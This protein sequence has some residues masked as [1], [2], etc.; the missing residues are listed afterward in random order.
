MDSWSLNS[1]FRTISKKDPHLKF[2]FRNN[3]TDSLDLCFLFFPLYL[4]ITPTP[5]LS[6]R[7]SSVDVNLFGSLMWDQTRLWKFKL[8]QT[9]QVV[10]R[11]L[12]TIP[13][14]FVQSVW[15]EDEST[16]VLLGPPLSWG[17]LQVCEDT[18]N[19]SR[20]VI[21]LGPGWCELRGGG[22][23]WSF[24]CFCSVST[25][26]TDQFLKKLHS[27]RSSEHVEMHQCTSYGREMQSCSPFRTYRRSSQFRN[28]KFII[29]TG[30]W[31]IMIAITFCCFRLD[32]HFITDETNHY[33]RK[34]H[35]SKRT[36][37]QRCYLRECMS[38][39]KRSPT[40]GQ[41]YTHITNTQI[42][43]WT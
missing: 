38:K 27:N 2:H 39:Y 1:F 26:F 10:V 41:T 31:T 19:R 36:N 40:R 23:W 34:S 8:T 35:E 32:H 30:Y 13:C 4:S 16:W 28:Y 17:N 29:A 11:V 20:R 42:H 12:S 25:V 9:N 5:T 22:R 21:V 15:W 18:D 7:A 33:E 24:P 6:F 37:V 3:L 43:T 14:T